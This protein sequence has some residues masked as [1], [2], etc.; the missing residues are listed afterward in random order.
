GRVFGAAVQPLVQLSLHRHRA[1][2][3]QASSVEVGGAG[4]VVAGWSESGKTETVLALIEGGGRFVTDKWTVLSEAGRIAPFPAAVF[5][6][7]WVLEYLP[8]LAASLSLK[9]K[10]QLGAGR[11]ASAVSR[12][13]RS[14]GRRNPALGHLSETFDRAVPLLD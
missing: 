5:I 6:R 11:I 10:G 13:V 1:V 2:A 7:R 4:L 14:I 12:P 8:R 3:V 9:A